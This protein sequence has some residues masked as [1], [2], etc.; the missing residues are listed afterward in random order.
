M[1]H[2]IRHAQAVN[3]A[4]MVTFE[5]RPSATASVSEEYH[6]VMPGTDGAIAMAWTAIDCASDIPLRE[7]LLSGPAS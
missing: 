5:V 6:P 1:L 2:R 3:D 7:R 4:K